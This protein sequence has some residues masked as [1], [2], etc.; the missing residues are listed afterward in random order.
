MGSCF[1]NQAFSSPINPCLI[2]TIGLTNVPDT[3]AS[4]SEHPTS[5]I[6][7]HSAPTSAEH[8]ALWFFEYRL[9]WVLLL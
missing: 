6:I 2:N 8:P 7:V 3:S 9:N 1:S 4:T 5:I